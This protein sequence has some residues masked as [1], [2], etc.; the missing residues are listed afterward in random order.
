MTRST[1]PKSI[2]ATITAQL[3]AAIEADPGRPELPWRRIAG[4]LHTPANAITGRTYN[5]INIISLWVAAATRG[6]A[7]PLW[8]TFRQWAERGCQVRKGEK[9]APVV[10]YREYEVDADPDDATDTGRRRVARA[11]H[12][13]NAAQVEGF[14]IPAL[15]P[16]LGPVERLAAADR[17]VTAT[18]ADIH[19][20]GDRAFFTP[21]TDSI[22]MPEQGLFTGSRSMSRAEGYYATLLHELVHWTGPAHRLNRDMYGRF[23]DAAYAAEELVAE[24]GSAFLC[25]ELSV[26]PEVRPDHAQYLASWLKLLKSDD[27]AIFTA[28]ARAAEAA[29]FL[30]AM[31]ATDRE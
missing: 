7:T 26:T 30:K 21:T 22:Q 3:I 1:E 18:G 16:S 29:A 28:A 10:F 4:A 24:I 12:V 20:G 13:F 5:G 23:G 8:A 6:Y 15:P 11:S 2:Y 19:H 9:S 31:Q 25:A 14:S 27:R 17:F